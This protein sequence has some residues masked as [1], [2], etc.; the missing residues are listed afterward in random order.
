MTPARL[1]RFSVVHVLV[2]ESAAIELYLTTTRGRAAA[3]TTEAGAVANESELTALRAGVP[4]VTFE[5]CLTVS[6]SSG[7]RGGEVPLS[8]VATGTLGAGPILTLGYTV[9]GLGTRA[10]GARP[11]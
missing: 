10:V 11:T 7:R 4:L 3:V 8:D 1:L 5:A 6:G 2:A 9:G